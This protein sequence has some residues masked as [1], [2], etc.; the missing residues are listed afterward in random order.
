MKRALL[1]QLFWFG[2]TGAAAAVTH[3]LVVILLVEAWGA[4]PL[5]ANAGGFLVAFGVSYLGH[6]HLT[7]AAGAVPARQSLPRFLLV[8]GLGFA[9]NEGLFALLLATTALPY[10]AALVLVLLAVAGVTFLLS[11][12]WAFMHAPPS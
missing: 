3:L 11:R 10:Q 7:F 5:V 12:Q 1:R 8:A 9:L 6:R 2:A 4:A